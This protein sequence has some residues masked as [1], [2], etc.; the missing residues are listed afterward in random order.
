MSTTTYVFKNITNT[1][2]HVYNFDPLKPHF[3]IQVIKRG[4]TGYTL[5]FFL[6]KKIDC[7]YSS[8]LPRTGDLVWDC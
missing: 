8:E 1:Y 7:W 6:L 2:L 5:F 3:Y 4:F